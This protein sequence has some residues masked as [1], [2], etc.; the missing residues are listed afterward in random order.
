MLER[1]AKSRRMTRLG[2]RGGMRGGAAR[3]RA[4]SAQER[5][6]IART[7]ARARWSRPALVIDRAPRDHG[8]LSALVAHYGARVARGIPGSNLQDIVLRAVISSRR[9]PALARMLPVFLWRT[10]D[11]L[12]LDELIRKAHKR[13]EV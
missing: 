3:A 11:V 10:R 13:G 7:A 1:M 9:D 12:D 2:R 6:K 4:L 8:E 5:A